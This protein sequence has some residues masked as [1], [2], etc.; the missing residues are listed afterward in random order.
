MFTNKTA[1]NFLIDSSLLILLVMLIVGITYLY[2]SSEH[3]FYFW[4]YTT[5]ENLTNAKVISF[6]NS[7]IKALYE[8]WQSTANNYDDVPTLL[9]VPF[10]LIFGDSRLV[11][12]LSIALVYLLPFVL[13][14]AAIAVKLI[15]SYPRA[16]YWSAALLTLLTPLTWLPTLRGYV[17][18]GA[19]LLIGLAILVYL[20]DVRLKHW[21]QMA[22]IGFLIATAALFR[23]HFVYDGIAFLVALALQTLV[24]FGTQVRQHRHEALGNLLSSSVRIGCTGAVSLITLAVVGW[25][26]IDAIAHTNFGLLYASYEVPL[27]EG[28]RYYGVSY[29]WL[30][31]MLAGLGMAAGIRTRVLA[32]PVASFIILFGSFALIQWVIKVKQ[33]GVHYTSH[34]TILIVLGL[35]AFGWTAGITLKGRTRSLVLGASCFYLIWN[36]VIGL[37]SVDTLNN[38]LIRPTRLGMSQIP[39]S[40][41]TK[42]SELFSANYPPLK[43]ADYNELLR[44]IEYLSTVASNKES[45][46]VAAT[47]RFLNY[48]IAGLADRTLHKGEQKLNIFV[49]ADIDSRDQYPLDLLLQAQYVVVATPFYSLLRPQEQKVV[50]VVMDAFN[51]NWEM[52]RDFT[53]LPVQF[54]LAD[55]AVVNVYKRRRTTSL[56][57]AVRTFRSMQNYIGKR[58]GRQGNWLSLSENPGY[59]IIEYRNTESVR[60]NSTYTQQDPATWFLYLNPLPAQFTITGQ[61]KYLNSHC[62]GASLRFAMMNAQ[63]QVSDTKQ[64]IHHR[65]DAPQLTM[66]LQKGDATNLLFSVSAIDDEKNSQNHCAIRI[67]NFALSPNSSSEKI[68]KL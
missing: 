63:N 50:K 53:R 51:E 24:A 48:S 29:G 34:F 56:E 26:F 23:R 3:T 6:R 43:R 38:T 9:L 36:A 4:D 46:Y 20:Q 7:P 17:D 5:Y 37:A 14:V 21:W 16:V 68:K 62:S 64:I 65:N 54:T 45:I 30:A 61:M 25:P 44:L 33:V 28:L 18:T 31:W 66:S 15:P 1:K 52:A 27:S 49:S 13:V 40:V 41:G 39:D 58:P 8:T 35:I 57:T 42:L 12:I 10:Q 2:V 11:Y 59:T 32:R 19:A 60:T 55:G 22:L 67:N 47:S